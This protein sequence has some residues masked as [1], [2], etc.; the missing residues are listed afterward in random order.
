MDISTLETSVMSPR[1]NAGHYWTQE[2]DFDLGGD[3]V[4]PRLIEETL[5]DHDGVREALAFSVPSELGVDEVWA[6]VVPTDSLDEEALQKHCREKLPQTQV[7]VRFI[8]VAEL[9]RTEN[10]K[11]DRRRLDA[12]V[13]GLAGSCG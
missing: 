6:L 11:V 9:P 5:T 4:S 8:N 1:K 10:G 13:Q 3:K 2:R 12:M 7:P